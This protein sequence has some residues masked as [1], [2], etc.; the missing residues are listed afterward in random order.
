[1]KEYW[2]KWQPS[3]AVSRRY[4][5]IKLEKDN[6]GFRL[7]VDSTDDNSRIK[8]QFAGRIYAYRST[9][10]LAGLSNFNKM[11]DKNGTNI[12]SD[13]TFFIVQNSNYVKKIEADSGVIFPTSQLIHF[14]IIASTTYEEIITDQLPE[15]LQGW[16]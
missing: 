3:I 5:L 15:I 8:I 9:M 16:D 7:F 4:D 13:G 11:N 2:E 14:A 10:E 6:D 12:V 1:M